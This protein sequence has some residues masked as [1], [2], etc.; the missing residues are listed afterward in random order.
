MS[1]LLTQSHGHNQ[2]PIGYNLK[3]LCTPE[4]TMVACLRAVAAAT[5]TKLTTA[6]IADMS[7]LIVHVPHAAHSLILQAKPAHL[8]TA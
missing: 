6:D 1:A 8:T 2:R 4:R 3:H 5:K 7:P